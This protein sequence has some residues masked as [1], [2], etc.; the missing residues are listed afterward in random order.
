L[1]LIYVRVYVLG[2]AAIVP[3]VNPSPSCFHTGEPVVLV[4][5]IKIA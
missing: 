1:L 3:S 4:L 5:I 2:V